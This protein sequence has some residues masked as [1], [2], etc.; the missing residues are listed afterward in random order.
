MYC[1]PKSAAV[2]TTTGCTVGT[3]T[4]KDGDAWYCK[5]DARTDGVK[6]GTWGLFKDCTDGCNIVNGVAQCGSTTG[7]S[8][9]NKSATKCQSGDIYTCDGTAW[10]MTTDCAIGCSVDG[11]GK[12]FCDTCKAG[13]ARCEGD[14]SYV[15]N[16]AG[17]AWDVKDCKNGCA[18]GKCKSSGS[19]SGSG[20]GGDYSSG[21]SV[22]PD[23]LTL[24][25]GESAT[26]TA[27]Q[28]VTWSSDTAT[29]ATVTS[30]GIV[31]GVSVGTATVTATT[32]LGETAT[33][34]VT[35]IA[36][37]TGTLSFKVSFA[38]IKPSYVNNS[39]ES[40]S[41]I[42]SL[43]DLTVDVL[44]RVSNVSQT[45]SGVQV[46]VVGNEI[47][48]KGNQVFQVSNLNVG[49][50]LVGAN[51]NNFV[52]VKGP[53]HLRRRMCVDGQSGKTDDATVCNINL[54]GRASYVYDFSEYTLL[55]GDANLDGVINSVDFSLVKNAVNADAELECGRQYDLNM[56]GVV[57][58]MDINLVKDAL[59]SKDDE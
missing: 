51:T 2:P 1:Y 35:V 45:L 32:A 19:G 4:C 6:S 44:N 36:S 20:G 46:S 26:V 18:D 34:A 42:G 38:G 13:T 5:Q 49:S 27:T 16:T 37:D 25:V 15:C 11:G 9:S 14:K 33:V 29:V 8:S 58:S 57:N 54:F 7:C 28:A 59:S 41:C 12:A 22:T 21:L 50:S 43:G 40:Y 10:S 24:K 48:S 30:E 17:N 52:K 39:G 31:T 3:Y 53:F 23:T 56:D 47:D 55:A